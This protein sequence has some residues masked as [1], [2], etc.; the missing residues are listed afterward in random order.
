MYHRR[1]VDDVAVAVEVV[2]QE[3][4]LYRRLLELGACEELEPFL[5]E[6]L[7]LIVQASRARKGYLEFYEP[8]EPQPTLALAHGCEGP[9]EDSFRAGISQG[10]MAEAMASRATVISASALDDPRF[11][12]RGS[13]RRHHIEAVLCTPLGGDPPLGVVYLQERIPSGSFDEADRRR[14][15]LFARYIGPFAERLLM[16]RWSKADDPTR[17][18]RSQLR[19]EGVI[20]RSVSLARMLQEVALIAPLDVCTVL[21]G[22]SGTGKTQIARVIHDSGPRR[23]HPFVELNCAAI[24]E[25]LLEAELFGA[26]PGAHS[27]ATRR[28][29]G[30]LAA[31]EGGTLFLD[32]IGELAVSAQAKLLQFLQSREYYPL[33]ANRP[34]RA[35]VRVL[36]ATNVD[37]QAAIE[38]KSFRGDLYYRLA[39]LPIR[40]PSLEERRDDIPELAHHFIEQACLK[41][42]LPYLRLSIAGRQAVLTA[43]WPGNVRQLAHTME[44]A[45]IR[46]AGAALPDI[47]PHHL[48]PGLHNTASDEPGVQS[49]QE[50]TRRFQEQILRAALEEQGWNVAETARRL[51]LSRAHVYNLI[52]AFGLTR[53]R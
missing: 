30:K 43:A 11:R 32:E 20:G 27:T 4:D 29:E 33:G 46:A 24:P 41:N 49:F 40:V 25:P 26:M 38:R 48:F 53:A 13:V 14:A 12:D 5:R 28:I 35:N 2:R 50:A 51:D 1:V 23:D 47:E 10:V 31:A 8:N 7:A 9:A 44:G 19:A 6:V 52:G 36:V 22:E 17:T 18:I 21:T 3:R 16:R 42:R 45:A 37:L 15:E 39:V 34:S